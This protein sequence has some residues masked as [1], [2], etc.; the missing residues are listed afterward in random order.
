MPLTSQEFRKP[1]LGRTFINELKGI[2]ESDPEE[3]R[4]QLRAA[5]KEEETRQ[6][7]ENE[8]KRLSDT[9]LDTRE[10]FGVIRRGLVKLDRQE[11][12]HLKQDGTSG[13]RLLPKLAPK[14]DIFREVCTSLLPWTMP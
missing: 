7:F 9:V 6:F 10:K 5:T 2:A 12:R 13:G 4:E 1:A 11:L 14:W 3:F 8:V